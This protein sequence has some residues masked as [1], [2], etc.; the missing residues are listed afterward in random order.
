DP[1]PG[2]G[3]GAVWQR[4]RFGHLVGRPV[5][6]LA[7]GEPAD[8][9]LAVRELERLATGDPPLLELLAPTDLEEGTVVAVEVDGTVAAVAPVTP[10]APDDD[11]DRV[12]HALLHPDAAGGDGRVAAH[13]VEG[14]AGSPT[15][16]P[17]RVVGGW[18]ARAATARG[19]P[20]PRQAGPFGRRLSAAPRFGQDR[21]PSRAG[22]G[23]A[24]AP[25]CCVPGGAVTVR[26]RRRPTAV[27]LLLAVVAACSSGGADDAGADPGDGSEAR[28]TRAPVP[29][30]ARVA[31]ER[32]RLTHVLGSTGSL[33]D[34]VAGVV[35][36]PGGPDRLRLWTSDDGELWEAHDPDVG[37]GHVR[38]WALATDGAATVVAGQA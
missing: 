4:T 16:R 11:G 13:V 24:P 26:V 35:A 15:L 6:E 3:E 21:R 5:A 17:L 22:A 8:A 30:V 29:E 27:A 31:G 23:A 18:A 36:E 12:V 9:E 7:V 19:E 38:V 2:E 10:A 34:V 14:P 25:A 32:A 28:W 20:P 37:E 33:P 1:V